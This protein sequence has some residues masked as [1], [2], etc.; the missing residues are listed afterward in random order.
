MLLREGTPPYLDEA[1]VNE[2]FADQTGVLTTDNR[3]SQV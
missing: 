2:A 3:P 1:P